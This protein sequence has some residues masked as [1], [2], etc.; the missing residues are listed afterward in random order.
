MTEKYHNRL[1]IV[2][3]FMVLFC[4]SLL[5]LHE[6]IGDFALY[7]I[8]GRSINNGGSAYDMFFSYSMAAAYFFR[9]FALLPFDVARVVFALMNCLMYVASVA[10]ILFFN[11]AKG[12]WFAYP[13]VLSCFWLPVA[14][15]MRVGNSDSMMLFL[16]TLSVLSAEKKQ[17]VLSGFLLGVA[18]LF[19]LFPIGIAMVMGLKNWRIFA[20]CVLTVAVSF[21]IPGSSGWFGAIGSVFKT[22]PLLSLPYYLLSQVHIGLFILYAVVIAAVTASICYRIRKE[23]N[24]FMFVSFAI[25]SVLLTMVIVE[26]IHLTLLAY[27]FYKFFFKMRVFIEDHY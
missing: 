4:I 26:Y 14:E 16:L 13:L 5:V 3:A 17:P 21:L 27:A 7:Y 22:P 24:Y 8:A 9:V 1:L 19:K 15:S 6:T 23:A 25:P 10:M 2:F 18:T 11:K 20:V 12:R